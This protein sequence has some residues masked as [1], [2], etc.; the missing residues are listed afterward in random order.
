V[1]HRHRSREE[2]DRGLAPGGRRG[3][4][5]HAS[6]PRLHL[7][8]VRLIGRPEANVANRP[9]RNDVHRLAAVGDDPVDARLGAELLAPEPDRLE[10]QKQRVERVAALPRIA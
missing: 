8:V 10:E 9:S 6:E 2:A 4:V 1:A 5:D 7:G 3:S